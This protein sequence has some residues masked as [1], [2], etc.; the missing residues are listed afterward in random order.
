MKYWIK[1]IILKSGELVTEH[2]LLPTEN[3]FE[4]TPP[5]VGDVLSVRCRDREFSARVVWGNW[6][7]REHSE[8]SVVFLRVQET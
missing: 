6:P 4:G 1:R 7:A 5:V 3:I 8:D 2:E